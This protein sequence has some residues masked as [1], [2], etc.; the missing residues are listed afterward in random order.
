M[1]VVVAHGNRSTRKPC[2]REHVNIGDLEGLLH[3]FLTTFTRRRYMAPEIMRNQ[4]Y[5][6]RQ[7]DIW[8]VA[9]ILLLGCTGE[10]AWPAPT[11]LPMYSREIEW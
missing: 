7:A 2:A 5:D 9:V 1:V 10:Y 11:S 4:D 8:S 6:G 3:S